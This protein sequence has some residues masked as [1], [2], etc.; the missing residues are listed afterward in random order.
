MKIRAAAALRAVTAPLTTPLLPDD[1]L[2]LLNPLWSARE[3]R[4]RIIE[5]RPETRDSATLAIKPGWGF[6]FDHQPFALAGHVAAL[7]V[8]RLE[9][10]QVIGNRHA[11]RQ[12]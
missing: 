12:P 1:Y 3:L 4:G 10:V 2:K 5:V 11:G 6:T 9:Q 8:D 7:A